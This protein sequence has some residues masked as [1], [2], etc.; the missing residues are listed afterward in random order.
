MS[1]ANIPMI[2]LR[3][4]GK[5]TE[6]PYEWVC[7]NDC[8]FT[9]FKKD[10]A[11]VSKYA[12]VMHIGKYAVWVRQP[13]GEAKQGISSIWLLAS[14]KDFRSWPTS[15]AYHKPDFTIQST[16]LPTITEDELEKMLLLA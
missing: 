12:Y 10:S 2:C 7:L 13:D 8:Q 1:E 4:S 3:C 16:L 6:Y 11:F 14:I 15:L 5:M 9:T